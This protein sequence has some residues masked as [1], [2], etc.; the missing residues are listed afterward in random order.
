MSKRA[1]LALRTA[2]ALALAAVCAAGCGDDPVDSEPPGDA[3]CVSTER[4]FS[5]QVWTPILNTTC[6]GCH[7]AQGQ[8]RDSAMVLQS[9]SQLGFMEHNLETVR[10]IAGFEFDGESVLLLRPTGRIEHPGGALI[11]EGSDEYKAL[12]ELVERFNNPVDCVDTGP[13]VDVFDDLVFLDTG[14]L[15]RKAALNLV[16]R[17]PTLDEENAVVDGGESSLDA[18]LVGMMAEE[19]FLDRVK[20]IYNDHLL[21][22]RY[23]GGNDATNLLNADDYP[24]RRWYDN[25]EYSVSDDV[26]AAGKQH[27]NDSLAREVLD[28]IAHVV[29]EGKPFTEVLTADYILVNGLSARIYGVEDRVSFDDETDPTELKPVKLP[30]VPHSGLLTS[31]MFLN[32]FPT[33]ATNRN[34]HRSRVVQ[35][36]FLATDVL[37]LAE[38][39]IDPTSIEDHNPTQFNANCTVCHE[40]VDPIAGTFQNWNDRG[41]FAPTEE[42]WHQ[43]M[44][45]PGFGDDVMPPARSGTALKWLAERIVADSRFARGA[46]HVLFEGITGQRPVAAPIDTS[47]PTFAQDQAAFE[48]QDA[49]FSAIATTFAES[50]HDLKTLVLEIVKSEYFRIDNAAPRQEGEPAIGAALGMGR[51]L[52]PEQLHRKIEAVTGY[53]WRRRVQDRDYLLGDYR[54]FFGGIDSDGVTER[55]TAPN[56]IMANVVWRMANE[57]GCT[58]VARDLSL[59]GEARRL[60]PH[61]ETSFEPEDENGFEI[62][63]AVAAI[64]ANIVHL[65]AHVLGERLTESDPEV[66]RTYEIFYETWKE[67]KALVESDDLSNQVDG[68][69][70]SQTDYWTGEDLPEDR[71]V[72]YDTNYTIRSWAAVMTYLLSDFRF[73]HE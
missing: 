46:L 36:L 11:V 52:T 23:L 22:D 67:G 56:G 34:R 5:E 24:D 28:L 6:V 18:V 60:L 29:R 31:P 71:Q 12:A 37:K 48:A 45:P 72:R 2:C 32:R 15:L 35:N 70:R 51:L 39:P 58:S 42:G 8:A 49:I 25:D 55:I 16:G 21:T 38:R 57:V 3:D 64:K 50:D 68:E 7:N 59:D 20:E 1:N 40:V 44:R 14:A 13:D 27:A 17:L 4:Y 63:Q 62:P 69:C 43:D 73:L 19:A 33:T 26:R 65:H 54:I 10:N 61:I 53:P 9:P 66:T 41:R 30:G 47:S